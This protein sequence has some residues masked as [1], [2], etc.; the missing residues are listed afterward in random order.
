M[1]AEALKQLFAKLHA[2]DRAWLMARLD[3]EQQRLL[4]QVLTS[5]DVQVDKPSNSSQLSPFWH[6]LTSSDTLEDTKPV[7]VDGYVV[8]PAVL[9]CLAIDD[10]EALT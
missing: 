1:N 10:G 2:D 5:T 4:R 3:N 7:T 9:K 8:P 6:L